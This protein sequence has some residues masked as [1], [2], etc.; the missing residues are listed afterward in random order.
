M[1]HAVILARG[2]GTRMRK[3]DSTA[4]LDASQAAM[5]DCGLKAMI[6]IGRPFLD[7]VLHVLAQAGYRKVCLVIGPEHQAVREY[8]AKLRPRRLTVEFAVQ[9]EPRGTADA[10]AAA[11]VCVGREPFLMINSDNYYPLEAV[12][13]LRRDVGAAIAAF[14]QD[15]M[16]AESN[17]PVE[18][19]NKFA[20]IEADAEGFL[21]KIHEKPDEATLR[22]LPKPLGM[23]MNCWRFGP[24]IFEACRSIVPSPRGELEITDAVQYAIDRLGERF[25]VHRYRAPVLDLSSRN[26]IAAVAQRLSSTEV[27]L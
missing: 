24:A 17:I 26:D 18:R 5:A 22:R 19:L 13:G 23:S 8:Y 14:D 1:D 6:P 25:R 7:Y 4:Q 10:V 21:V 27:D 2:L 15:A 3:S 16:V 11:E 20:V 12:E 9:V